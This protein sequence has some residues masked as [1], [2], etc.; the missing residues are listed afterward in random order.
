MQAGKEGL[1]AMT[2]RQ[3]QTDRI[4]M[5]RWMQEGSGQGASYAGAQRWEEQ[6]DHYQPGQGKGGGRGNRRKQ[7]QANYGGGHQW[8]KRQWD[9]DQWCGKSGAK[10]IQWPQPGA[11]GAGGFVKQEPEA[12]KGGKG[13]GKRKQKGGKGEKG[14]SPYD[15]VPKDKWARACGGERGD[16]GVAL[17]WFHNNKPGGCVSPGTGNGM[18]SW[19]HGK[20]PADYGDKAWEHLD[21]GT[22]AKI[23]AKVQA[24]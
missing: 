6:Q 14:K 4:V 20:R 13:K 11:D 15:M 3:F 1:M 2:R 9:D 18:C 8:G 12:P 10:A 5:A 7:Q 24:A 23:V 19:S 21:E 16:D 22:K 17:C